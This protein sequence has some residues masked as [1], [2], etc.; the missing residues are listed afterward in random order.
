MSYIPR[1]NSSRGKY[2]ARCGR[3]MNALYREKL[4]PACMEIELFSK[5]KEYIRENDVREQDVAEYFN[6]SVKQV[7]EWIREGRIQ[8]K[9]ESI[10]GIS[11][12]NCKICGKPI[13]FGVTCAECHPFHQLQVVAKMQKSEAAK[14]HFLGKE[15][16]NQ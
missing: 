2:C 14:M 5:V 7:R 6:I 4:C 3:E 11:S 15:N 13:A 12:V 16:E 9:D 8:Y 1:S 10:N